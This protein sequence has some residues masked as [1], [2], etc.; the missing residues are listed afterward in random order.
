MCKHTITSIALWLLVSTLFFSQNVWSS[1]SAPGNTIEAENC[2][3][4][5]SEATWD[6]PASG[7]ATIQGFSDDISVNVGQTINFKISTPAS[8]YHLD[9]YRMG[10]YQGNGARLVTTIQPSV[11][12]P[13]T[14]PN[15]VTNPSVGL[16][17]CGNWGVS[18]SWSVPS[19]AVSGIYF[20]RVIRNDT[21][22]ASHIFFIV[23]N[24]ASHSDILFQAS[25]TTWQAYNDSINGQNL[26]GDDSCGQFSPSC[27]AYKVSY[28]RPFTTRSFESVSWVM[29]AEYPMVRWLEANGYDVTY[30]TDTDTDRNG[31][32]I[33]NH[34]VW[35]SNGHDE[36][37][38]GQQRT[39]IEAAR[40]AGV[41]LA[42]FSGNTMFWKTRWENSIDGNNTPYRTLVCYKETYLDK[43]DPL[44]APIWTGTW[45]DARFSPPADGARPENAIKG[46]LFKVN[47]AN[48]A[49]EVPA[50]NAKMRLWRNTSVASLTS[51]LATLAPG[52][53]GSEVDVDEDNGFRPAGLIQL[54]ANTITDSS[55]ILLDEGVTYGV[56]SVKHSL[57][58]YRHPSGALVFSTGTYGWSWGLDNHHDNTNL[59]SSTDASMQQATVNLLA[60]MGIQPVSLEANLL[61]ATA[62]TDNSPPAST[63]TS[64]TAGSTITAGA[65]VTISGTASDAGGVV[66]GVEVS[67][68]GGASWHPASGLGTWIYPWIASANSS[69]IR[70]RAVDDSGNLETPNAG[71]TINGS[72]S[73]GG[74]G[75]G[76]G[77]GTGSGCASNCSSIWLSTSVPTVVDQGPDNDPVELG[78]KFKSDVAGSI[79]GIRFYKASTNTGIHTGSLWSST[80]TLLASAT[81]NAETA[82]G[83][84]QVNFSSPVEIAPN[85]VY[86]ASY[87]TS[88]GHY[89]ADSNY[90]A[91]AGI[92]SP[93]LHALQS[94]VSEFNG[95]Y[96]Y[97]TSSAFPTDSYQASNYWV[98][99]VFSPTLSSLTVTP[100]NAAILNGAKQQFTVNG[101]YSNGTVQNLTSQ[102]TWNSSNTSV[103]TVNAS[104]LA[105]AVGVGVTNLTAAFGG[106]TSNVATLIVNAVPGGPQGVPNPATALPISGGTGSIPTVKT[107]NVRISAVDPIASESPGDSGRFMVSLNAPSKRNLLVKFEDSG[108]ATKGRDYRRFPNYLVIPA[109]KVSGTIEILPVDDVKKE[110]TERVTLKLVGEGIN[111]YNVR[112]PSVATVMILDNDK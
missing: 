11:A 4:G 49:I 103:A 60:D 89:S 72:G 95:V 40:N 24:D 1:C 101:T 107:P 26:Y 76:G 45:R 55:N 9:I 59:G 71:I 41:H 50:T 27:R 68:D 75:S 112:S 46:N 2:L 97:S 10:Y 43:T 98:D 52:T 90:F 77:A 6:V 80:G 28:N 25:D 12:L 47:A 94:G 13:Q 78:V 102:T 67:T 31:A 93:P 87:H 83:W 5:T 79:T 92:D 106:I 74:N 57:T 18:A 23:R 82:S 22:G 20:A 63:I 54:S 69:V 34:K 21:Q 8:A 16:Y 85:T 62:S 64:P 65:M 37:W 14:Q 108:K 110:G 7:D 66:A 29:S 51:G 38:S 86:V 81:F 111:G 100:A 44:D 73:G 48:Y 84:Q 35:M 30:F 17:D 99:V 3:P 109:G 96:K 32:L 91:N 19:T 15:C 70:S 105:T 88:A 104:G 42:F 33:L 53:L 39:N 56:G 61:A 36:Y 58:M